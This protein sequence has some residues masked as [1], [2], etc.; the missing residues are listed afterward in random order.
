MLDKLT[1]EIVDIE[2]EKYRAELASREFEAEQRAISALIYTVLG[3]G[4][5]FCLLFAINC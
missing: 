5:G 2:M 4:L 3:T 1:K